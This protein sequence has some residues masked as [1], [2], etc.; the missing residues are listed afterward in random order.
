[1]E[2]IGQLLPVIHR[3]PKLY[4][5]GVPVVAPNMMPVTELVLQEKTG[6]LYYGLNVDDAVKKLYSIIVG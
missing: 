6:M 4:L 3:R 2:K 1:M 5:H